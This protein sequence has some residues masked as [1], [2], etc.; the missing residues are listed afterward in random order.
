M[1]RNAKKKGAK[2]QDAW[3]LI[4]GNDEAA[5]SAG[6]KDVLDEAP[7]SV[8]TGRSLSEIEAGHA[9]KPARRAP[10]KRP[11][12]A[13]THRS[14]HKPASVPTASARRGRPL[15]STSKSGGA[16]S[17]RAAP[18]KPGTGSAAAVRLTHPERPYWAN[19]GLTKQDLADYYGA[20]WD[21]AAA[22]IVGRPLAL[23]RCP[24]GTAGQC[25]FQKHA[26][27]GLSGTD[28]R[29]VVDRNG[30]QV[31][32][33][34]DL[35]GMLSLVQFGALEV[36]VRGSRIDRL[37]ICDRLV[38]DL[39]PGEG[40]GWNAVVAAARAVRERLQALEL[41]SFVK[42]S[43]GKGLHVVLPT[44]GSDWASA[45]A[46]AEA[47][48]R[49]LAADEPERYVAKMAK[50]QRAGKIFV[51]YLRNS[52]EQTSVA[53]YSTRA[54]PGAPVSIPVSWQELGRTTSSNQYSVRD[55]AK[56]L[57]VLK[58]DPWRDIAR[59]RQQLP[60]SGSR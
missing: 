9:R 25:F 15:N 22:Q 11:A 40:V 58:T 1:R 20:V 49:S 21:V 46:F 29:I 31:L 53:A 27:G 45:K 2:K 16:R 30:R 7:L 36:H 28:L 42:L 38:F 55:V 32:A 44:D 13:G 52:L 34:D 26:S 19:I 12:A 6:G 39:D 47:V 60:G 8:A 54:R 59:V 4:K 48:A 37:D 10:S 56:R 33:V 17:R 3:L 43:G 5:R 18:L 51:D 50:S 57:K 41:E 24:D 35:A 23:V 14:T